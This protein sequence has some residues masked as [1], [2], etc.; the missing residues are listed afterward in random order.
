[1]PTTKDTETSAMDAWIKMLEGQQPEK[2]I[3]LGIPVRDPSSQPI[4]YE[5]PKS[6]EHSAALG[7]THI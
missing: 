3:P 4:E 1:M 6:A 5:E 7:Y 2:Q